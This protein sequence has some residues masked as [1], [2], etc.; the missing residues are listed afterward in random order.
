MQSGTHAC[1]FQEPR[2]QSSF[3]TPVTVVTNQKR[4]LIVTRRAPFVAIL[5][6]PCGSDAAPKRS[7]SPTA[8]G[9][10]RFG[11]PIQICPPCEATGS[12]T[13][14]MHWRSPPASRCGAIQAPNRNRFIQPTVDVALHANASSNG[15]TWQSSEI[16]AGDRW[17]SSQLCALL[18]PSCHASAGSAAIR[19]ASTAIF[20]LAMQ[21]LTMR[22]S[23]R[24]VSRASR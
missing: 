21:R 17:C 12:S 13:G 2:H 15:C 20:S 18:S 3:L 16:F 4:K 22:G 24:A 8:T 11:D 5:L 6:V 7:K 10:S 14:R 19:L 23:R 1:I 9:T